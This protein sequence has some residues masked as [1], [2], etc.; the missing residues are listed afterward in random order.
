[1]REEYLDFF[2]SAILSTARLLEGISDIF[3]SKRLQILLR[4]LF[5]RGVGL[6]QVKEDDVAQ[7]IIQQ[8]FLQAIREIN[9]LLEDLLYLNLVRRTPLLV[10]RRSLMRLYLSEIRVRVIPKTE[11]KVSQPPT[12]QTEM[13]RAP[14]HSSDLNENQT[15]ILGFIKK[16]DRVRARD[17]IDQFSALSQRTVK[18][19]LKELMKSGLIEK[20]AEARAVFYSLREG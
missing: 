20:E 18:R 19:S 2:V 7:Y 5:I 15:K 8:E 13:P 9:R 16:F 10:A 14:K 17:V 11:P 4:Q 6:S 3:F 12:E 1:M